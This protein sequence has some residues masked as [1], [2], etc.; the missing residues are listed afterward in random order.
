MSD[1]KIL[2]EELQQVREAQ[3][4]KSIAKDAVEDFE[5]WMTI[6]TNSMSSWDYDEQRDAIDDDLDN[7]FDTKK[8][9]KSFMK[10][11][12]EKIITAI[13]DEL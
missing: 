4:V 12:R 11:N 9:S 13:L 3:S 1:F 10:N 5:D 8:L 7:F 2:T 6:N